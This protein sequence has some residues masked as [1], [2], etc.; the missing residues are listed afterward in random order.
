MRSW[1]QVD[2]YRYINY[3]HGSIVGYPGVFTIKPF[4]K[5]DDVV[6]P[7]PDLINKNEFGEVAGAVK[8]KVVN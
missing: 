4:V 2:L 7:L 6:D 8:I 5:I 3:S 1:N